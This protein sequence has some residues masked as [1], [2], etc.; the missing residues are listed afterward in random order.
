LSGVMALESGFLFGIVGT[1]NIDAEKFFDEWA[2]TAFLIASGASFVTAT[3]GWSIYL[4]VIASLVRVFGSPKI[5][6]LLGT[7]N[8]CKAAYFFV[9]PLLGFL[10]LSF[11]H[12][13]ARIGY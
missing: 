3:F 4:R 10:I 7:P 12:L 2:M 6:M 8:K 9:T 5:D 11:V 1:S 13:L